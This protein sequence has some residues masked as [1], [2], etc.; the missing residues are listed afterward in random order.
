MLKMRKLPT[1]ISIISPDAGL[2]S[3]FL[4]LTP[5][6]RSEN[7]THTRAGP[8]PCCSSPHMPE[9][10]K[11]WK[12]FEDE[13]LSLPLSREIERGAT[14]MAGDDA[15]YEQHSSQ[16]LSSRPGAA[17]SGSKSGR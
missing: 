5:P 14:L 16:A 8:R 17:D 13:N 10:K 11:P 2:P 7:Q 4:I 3:F 15:P 6:N 12:E 9:S 1:Y